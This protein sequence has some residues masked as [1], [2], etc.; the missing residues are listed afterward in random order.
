MVSYIAV[1]WLVPICGGCLP[2]L[3]LVIV[4]HY[5]SCH[6]FLGLQ[7]IDTTLSVCMNVSVSI[8]AV[9]YIAVCALCVRIYA[10]VC[11]SS[12]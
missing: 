9:I 2:L 1:S 5:S 11:L 10:E 4:Y 12:N 6:E 7:T 3:S 8:V